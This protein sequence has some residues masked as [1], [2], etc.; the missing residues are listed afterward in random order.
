MT[1]GKKA[2][3]WKNQS[4]Q[5]KPAQYDPNNLLNAIIEQLNLKN[6]AALS[7]ALDVSPPV[8][9]K[10]RHN[11]LPIGASMLIRIHEISDLSIRELR[12]LMGDQ[13]QRYRIGHAQKNRGES[14][15]DQ[16]AA[17]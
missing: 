4:R 17:F 10:I 11:H 3:K 5:E 7:R 1:E 8:I 13:R 15:P 2:G 9:S 16:P 6:D 12:E 14:H